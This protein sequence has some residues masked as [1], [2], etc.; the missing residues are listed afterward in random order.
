MKLKHIIT[1]NCTCARH[2]FD[3]CGPCI[4]ELCALELMYIIILC[5]KFV[6]QTSNFLYS[7]L[8]EIEN[9]SLPSIVHGTVFMP[10][11]HGITE[12]CVFEL[13]HIIIYMI[14]E[15]FR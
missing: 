7:N 11:G 15:G 1:I 3:G 5:Y 2:N 10:S 12:L 13:K 6:E 4:T 8:N 9:I 14:M